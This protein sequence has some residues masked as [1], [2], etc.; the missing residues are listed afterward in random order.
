MKEENSKKPVGLAVLLAATGIASAGGLTYFLQQNPDSTKNLTH[1]QQQEL[2]ELM[3]AI[4]AEPREW[5]LAGPN[6]TEP[7][8]CY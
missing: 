8:R 4:K 7:S 1:Q 3:D 5:Q 6:G 2:R